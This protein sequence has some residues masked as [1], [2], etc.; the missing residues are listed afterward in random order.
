MTRWGMS[1]SRRATSN[2]R[3]RNLRLSPIL[4]DDHN[5]YYYYYDYDD[6]YYY[7]GYYDYYYYYYYNVII[8]YMFS[9]ITISIAIP[10]MIPKNHK[11]SRAAFALCRC[12]RLP[13]PPAQRW[14]CCPLRPSL[15]KGFPGTPSVQVIEVT[16][17]LCQHSYW[18]WPF[19]VDFP[20]KNCD[21]P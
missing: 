12:C 14:W 19:I 18:K 9:Y 20:I 7:Y 21:F 2:Q 10:T 6:Y 5:Y 4:M 8:Y 13:R 1:T 3:L 11:P 16:L 15:K 17:W